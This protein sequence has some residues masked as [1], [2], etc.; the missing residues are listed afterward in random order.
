MS[1]DLRSPIL[2]PKVVVVY[3]YDRAVK[4]VKWY[5]GTYSS[6][7]IQ[8]SVIESSELLIESSG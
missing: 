4:N 2:G 7:E 6:L 3:R 1:S 5:H 8:I